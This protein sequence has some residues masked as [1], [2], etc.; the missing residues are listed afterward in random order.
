ML[1]KV[2]K[3]VEDVC[4]F[5]RKNGHGD[6]TPI[7]FFDEP[8]LGRD[9]SALKTMVDFARGLGAI[10]G[11]HDCGPD[12][13]NAIAAKPDLLSFDFAT[14]GSH[15]GESWDPLAEFVKAGGSL[16]WGAISTAPTG[17]RF[18]PSIT[19]GAIRTAALRLT[20]S[21]KAARELL[22]RSLITPACGTALLEPEH[23]VSLHARAIQVAELL[24]LGR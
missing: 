24:R 12:F 5:T 13:R 17:K 10:V 6:A 3:I 11:V 8:G 9:V 18:D 4:G 21:D 16:A 22:Q 7:V 23:A 20:G 2:K 1:D 19:G 15:V 14:Y